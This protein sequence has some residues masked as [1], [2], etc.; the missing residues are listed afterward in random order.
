MIVYSLPVFILQLFSISGSLFITLEIRPTFKKIIVQFVLVIIPAIYL[1]KY[2]SSPFGILYLLLSSAILFYRF[3]RN[4]RAIL[5]VTV[6]GI[7]AIVALNLAEISL[8]SF[9]IKINPSSILVST[10]IFL[11][12]F[13]I[14]IC[15]YKLFIEKV[16]KPIFI[17]IVSRLILT[18][19]SIV[20][21]GVLYINLFISVSKNL[22]SFVLFNL[23]IEAIY[24]LMMLL[25]SLILIRTV[26]KENR[27]RQKEIEHQQLL[28]YME[29]L[30]RINDNMQKFR[31]D[32]QNILLTMK[33][34]IN[35]NDLP[36]LQTYFNERIVKVEE[37]TLRSNYLYNQ[38]DKLELIELKG[39]I[40]TKI[41][42]ADEYNI[43][44][45]IEV[46]ELIQKIEIDVIDLTRVIGILL[47]NAIEASIEVE[48]PKLNL[49]LIKKSDHSVL[50][51][52]ENL[53]RKE[54]LDIN[55]VFE[56]NYSTKS[57]HRGTG[58]ATV[59]EILANH[60][61]VTMNTRIERSFF[62]HEL[63][64]YPLEYVHPSV[65]ND[66]YLIM[67]DF[68]KGGRGGVLS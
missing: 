14:F 23:I 59:R 26:K 6:L 41:L 35:H 8:F 5:D 51:I 44:M 49:A 64:I 57:N 1:Y 63:S 27:L 4:V 37:Q 36:G 22:Y 31:H 19:I 9:F 18:A 52:L 11:L 62:I 29:S 68:K 15:L 12:F 67:T 16:W 43:E 13:A 60:P 42:I 32:Y 45:N 46:P 28:D 61:N 38:L 56:R 21:V 34:Y 50:I 24:F 53:V 3:T 48:H 66:Q 33:G 47:D 55:R 65:Q 20:T 2:W 7:A 40:A 39:L 30:E 25:L 54:L 17:T 10:V 58:L